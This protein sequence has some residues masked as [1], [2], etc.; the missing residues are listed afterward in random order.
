MATTQIATTPALAGDRLQAPALERRRTATVTWWAIVRAVCLAF[1]VYVMLKWVTGP[2][3]KT[4]PSGPS[5]PPV[6]MRA[7]L[8]SWQAAGIAVGLGLL[9]WFLVRPWRRE[10]RM[11][12]DGL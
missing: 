2:Y 1:E 3:F 6:W 9:Y 10:R 8:I 4:V 7:I 12:F 5:V 11:T